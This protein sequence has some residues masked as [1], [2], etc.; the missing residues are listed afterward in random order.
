M[1]RRELPD[2]AALDHLH[3]EAATLEERIS[4]LGGR[5]SRALQSDAEGNLLQRN[6]LPDVHQLHEAKQAQF[7]RLGR[8]TAQI[9]EIELRI[10][11]RDQQRQAPSPTREQAPAPA[12]DV[13]RLGWLGLGKR[14]PAAS[15]RPEPEHDRRNDRQHSSPDGNPSRTEAAMDKTSELEDLRKHGLKLK[16]AIRRTNRELD[17]ALREAAAGRTGRALRILESRF[18]HYADLMFELG[19]VTAQI[20]D[21]QTRGPVQE[22]H[23][24]HDR[25]EDDWQE[26]TPV[27]EDRLSW[28]GLGEAAREPVQ[29]ER[30]AEHEREVV[31]DRE[32]EDDWDLWK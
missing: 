31:R 25:S 2:D 9:E 5:I 16:R 21:L 19:T 3:D 13:D 32:P 26:R 7:F 14:E 29:D 27:G 8:V 22:R 10:A 20:R 30:Y 17:R 18:E 23:W 11:G 28:L 12:H 24:Q 15:P 6:T 1:T 4:D